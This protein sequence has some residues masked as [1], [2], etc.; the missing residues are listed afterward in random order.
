MTGNAVDLAMFVEYF[1]G[2][3]R[4]QLDWSLVRPETHQV[5]LAMF[6]EGADLGDFYFPWYLDDADRQVG[7]DGPR[8]RP[9]SVDESADAVDHFEENRRE[10]IRQIE[11]G[12]LHAAE[13]NRLVVA[14]YALPGARLLLLD[15]GHHLAAAALAGRP[16]IAIEF[17]L[18][19]SVDSAVLPDLQFW[20]SRE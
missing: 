11:Q 13:P 14:T 18:E 19:G 9:V 20:T 6:D 12:M 8:A 10:S 3:I 4:V 17:R 16:F 5:R 1:Q 15:G 7:Y 2:L